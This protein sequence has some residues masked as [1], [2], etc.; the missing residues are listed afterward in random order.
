ML[1][2]ISL[3]PLLLACSTLI[4]AEETAPQPNEGEPFFLTKVKPLLK[5]KCFGCHGDGDELES[6]FDMRTR[7]GVLEGGD[8][9][10]GA[11]SG[12]PEESTS[13]CCG[14]ATW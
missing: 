2:V 9:D 4:V 8:I 12:K 10:V 3:L 13:R 11:V 1:R 6:N 14:R 7:A 5:Q